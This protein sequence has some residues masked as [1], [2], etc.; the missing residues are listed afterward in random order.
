MGRSTSHVR[1]Q[2][3]PAFRT[4]ARAAPRA[5]SVEVA[6]QRHAVTALDGV[7]GRAVDRRG[8]GGG[9]GGGGGR[10][11]GRRGVRAAAS[12]CTREPRRRRF[13][14]LLLAARRARRAEPPEWRRAGVSGPRAQGNGR[15]FQPAV[16]SAPARGQAAKPLPADPRFAA[17][18]PYNT[19]RP[20]RTMQ[21]TGTVL[22]TALQHIT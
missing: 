22:G 13:S 6:R 21:Y 19:A 8:G 11:G 2:A 17:A 15:V 12:E 16:Q 5:G 9:G 18:A 4:G 3:P 14:P 20:D 10:M 1:M 7:A